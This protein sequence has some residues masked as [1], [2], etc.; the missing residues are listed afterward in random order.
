MPLFAGDT[1]SSPGGTGSSNLQVILEMRQE[2]R[3]YTMIQESLKLIGQKTEKDRKE[4]Q[5]V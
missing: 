1:W 4:R 5:E 3:V 2:R